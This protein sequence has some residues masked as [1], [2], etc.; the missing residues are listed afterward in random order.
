MSVKVGEAVERR[1]RRGM[2][3]TENRT[4]G[5]VSVQATTFWSDTAD[6]KHT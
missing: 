4:T 5:V 6:G 2:Y 1:G 3:S